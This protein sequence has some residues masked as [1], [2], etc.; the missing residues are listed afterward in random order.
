MMKRTIISHIFL[1]LCFMS[2]V[3]CSSQDDIISQSDNDNII[4]VGNVSTDNMVTTATVTRTAVA[5]ETLPWLKEALKKGMDITYLL[6][7]KKKLAKSP[8]FMSVPA[9]IREL[10]KIEMVRQ[11]DGV[12]RLDHAVT[13]TQKA[14]LKAFNLTDA[15]VKYVA[16]EI[17]LKLMAEKQEG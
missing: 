4:H 8:N 12:Y 13:A 1:M 15:Y 3:A 16:D 9:S 17:R 5:A 2:F 6:D 11:L 14:I 7:E 10:D